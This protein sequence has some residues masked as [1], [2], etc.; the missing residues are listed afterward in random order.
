MRQEDGHPWSMLSCW[1][2]AAC[3]ISFPVFSIEWFAVVGMVGV[4]IMSVTVFDGS[5]SLESYIPGFMS[6]S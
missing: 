1:V 3:A 5:N 2:G 4:G 6:G